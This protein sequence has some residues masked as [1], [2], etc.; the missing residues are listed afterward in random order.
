[1][2]KG[3]NMGTTWDTEKLLLLCIILALFGLLY[4]QAV[5]AITRRKPGMTS[6]AVA[7][8]VS[9]NIVTFGFFAGW[10]HALVLLLFFA[11]SGAP[12]I[13]GNIW[14]EADPAVRAVEQARTDT[15]EKIDKDLGD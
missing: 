3:K 9:V 7:G 2:E 11:T 13:L 5:P 1:M 15:I 12:M 14:R 10:D 4:N 8:G 6:L